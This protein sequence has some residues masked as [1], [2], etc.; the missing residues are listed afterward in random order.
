MYSKSVTLQNPTG[1]HARPAAV[2][3]KAASQFKSE[4]TITK[5]SKTVSAKSLLKLLS[6][7]ITQGTKIII[8][9]SGEDETIAV[10]SLVDLV[11]SRFGE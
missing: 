7:G 9:A 3:V 5:D 11:N 1:L 4:V 6:L 2:F 10:D 8:E